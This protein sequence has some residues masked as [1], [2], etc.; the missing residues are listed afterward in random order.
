M[1]QTREHPK[2][3][4]LTGTVWSRKRDD[5]TWLGRLPLVKA[6]IAASPG[7]CAQAGTSS[8]ATLSNGLA[9]QTG[10]KRLVSAA[11]FATITAAT[12]AA[13]IA[14]SAATTITTAAFAFGTGFVDV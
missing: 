7:T 12:T 2:N 5:H 1:P 9:R 11:G 3:R 14:A 13:A 10:K 6:A 8:C 4:G